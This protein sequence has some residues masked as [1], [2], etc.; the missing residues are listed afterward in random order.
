MSDTHNT[1]DLEP[2][3]EAKLVPL[4]T[5]SGQSLSAFA[6][7]VLHRHA[8]EQERLMAEYTEDDIR[9]ERYLATGE[10][11]PAEVVL[12]ELDDMAAEAMRLQKD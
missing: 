7:S 1:I 4:A 11:V 9:W 10:S 6:Q 8:D 12:R 5:R 2:E 3:L